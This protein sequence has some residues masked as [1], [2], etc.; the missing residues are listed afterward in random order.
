MLCCVLRLRW[1]NVNGQCD[2]LAGCFP[3]GSCTKQS[4]GLYA[5][6]QCLWK[7]YPMLCLIRSYSTLLRLHKRVRQSAGVAVGVCSV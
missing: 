3:S 1:G 2:W 7:P 4:E 6:L 5:V